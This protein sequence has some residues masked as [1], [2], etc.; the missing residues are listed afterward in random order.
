MKSP[1]KFLSAWFVRCWI[2]AIPAKPSSGWISSSKGSDRTG[3]TSGIRVLPSYFWKIMRQRSCTF[4][5]CWRFYPVNLRQ[6]LR[7]LL[8]MSCCCSLWAIPNSSFWNRRW[9]APVRTSPRTSLSS[10]SPILKTPPSGNTSPP[11]RSAF[12][13]TRCAFMA[14][15]GPPTPRPFLPLSD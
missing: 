3:A 6:S 12:A 7:S 8:S 10:T 1:P 4:P 9:P 15:C 11:T 5:I 13:L 14:R 2:L